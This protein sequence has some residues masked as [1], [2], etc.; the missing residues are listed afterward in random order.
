MSLADPSTSPEGPAL[1][2]FRTDLRL[3]DNPA[4][5]VAAASGAP[6]IGL[7][8]LDEAGRRAAARRGV[9]VVAGR[10][11]AGAQ[12]GAGR[13]RRAAGSA[14]RSGDRDRSR[15]AARD[16]RQPARLQSRARRRPSTPTTTP[17]PTGWRRRCPTSTWRTASGA[18]RCCTIPAAPAGG[19][20]PRSGPISARRLRRRRR[21]RRPTVFTARR[22]S[23]PTGSK[24]GAW[25]RPRRTGP[26]ACAKP[27]RRARPA[28]RRGS[29][30]FLDHGLAG[31]A[32]LRDRPDL[33]HVSRLS[34]H[35]RFGEITPAQ[36]WHAAQT[37]L[38]QRPGHLARRREVPRRARLAR[39]RLQSPAPSPGHGGGQSP[40]ALRRLPLAA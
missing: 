20:S 19:C 35:L 18:R 23:P 21:C 32:T 1:V 33:D 7:Y 30:T 22:R 34:P 6:L 5:T 2:W 29:P 4:L 16:R 17:S 38:G 39:V 8:V 31:Y 37:A 40:A 26:A 12:G 28:P 24:T 13:A 10:L 3:A 36:V 25:S 15:G 14:P 11:A 9:A 27:G